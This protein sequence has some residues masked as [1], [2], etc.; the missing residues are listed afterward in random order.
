[1]TLTLEDG[2]SVQN[3]DSY[4]S[5]DT[6]IT[7]GEEYSVD[8]AGFKSYSTANREAL[9]RMAAVVLDTRWRKSYPG[10]KATATQGLQ[11]PRVS[12]YD[13]EGWYL[14]SD[15]VPAVV[16]RAHSHL[17]LLAGSGVDIA[18]DA[19][20]TMAI[21][22]AKAASGAGVVFSQPISAQQFRA[23]H[24]L[25]EPIL[26]RGRKWSAVPEGMSTWA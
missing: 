19:D 21:E 2:T 18:A 11:W 10:Q 15:A 13:A 9:C 5:P 8:T 26:A 3:A 22:E 4:S 7:Y 24:Q 25:L 16:V 23:V 20:Q 6:V 14:E 12:A 17:A 1:V